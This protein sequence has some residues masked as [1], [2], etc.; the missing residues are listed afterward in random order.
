MFVVWA[1][2]LSVTQRCGV[3]GQEV[4]T[5]LKRVTGVSETKH[6]FIPNVSPVLPADSRNHVVG[7]CVSCK[8]LRCLCVPLCEGAPARSS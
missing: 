6:P 2:A 5:R 1:S 8:P 4:V 3:G 7:V